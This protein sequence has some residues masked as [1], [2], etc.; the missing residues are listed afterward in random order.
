MRKVV[1]GFRFRN[2]LVKKAIK[3]PMYRIGRF[4]INEYELR[5]MQ[6]SV[7]KGE[8]LNW[9]SILIEDDQGMIAQFD[10]KGRLNKNLYGMDLTAESAMKYLQVLNITKT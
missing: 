5:E 1:T 8:I 7:L 2:E 3:V 4:K 6:I 9:T 10:I